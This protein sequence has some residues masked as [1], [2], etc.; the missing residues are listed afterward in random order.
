MSHI[1]CLNGDAKG[2]EADVGDV[3]KVGDTVS[4]P[5][6][7]E[8]AFTGQRYVHYR[9]SGLINDNYLLCV[10]K[11]DPPEAANE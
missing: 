6:D 3:L 11:L 9:V 7:D 2:F 8:K 5:I 10:A 1:K 4:I